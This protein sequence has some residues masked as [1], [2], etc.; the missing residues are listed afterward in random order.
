MKKLISI[1]LVTSLLL[2]CATSY[3]PISDL[4]SVGDAETQNEDLNLIVGIQPPGENNRFNDTA[5]ENN[6][7]ILKLSLENISRDTFSVS[8][9]NIYLRGITENEPISQL[10]PHEVADRMALVTGAYW[11]WGLLWFGYY[12]NEN[13]DESSLWIPIGLPI[14]LYNFLK[15]ESTNSDFEDEITNNAFPSGKIAPGEIK[16]GYLFF[17]RRGGV[18][19]NLVISYTDYMGNEKEIMIPYKF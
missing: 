1:L 11:L 16:N 4:E 7:T 17:N 15:A 18:K 5:E 9:K 6:I 2:S 12:H 8:N 13:G 10:S 19:Y 14:A 3:H